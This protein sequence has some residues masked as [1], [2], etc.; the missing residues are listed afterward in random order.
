[1]TC[2]RHNPTRTRVRLRAL[3]L[4]LHLRVESICR[5]TSTSITE[6]PTTSSRL[7]V[8]LSFFLSLS[9]NTS[10]CLSVPVSTQSCPHLSV[11]LYYPPNNLSLIYLSN[12]SLFCLYTYNLI[13]Q[14]SSHLSCQ[15]SSSC[16]FTTVCSFVSLSIRQPPLFIC[17]PVCLSVIRLSL[18][19]L[20]RQLVYLSTY[21]VIFYPCTCSSL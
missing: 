10:I 4:C 19:P 16:L 8:W 3:N 12:L 17:S 1:M 9:I 15:N 13:L 6:C 11:Y 20:T 7:S 21:N 18:H 5:R 2:F 14:M